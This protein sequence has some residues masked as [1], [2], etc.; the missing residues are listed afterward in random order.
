[1]EKFPNL[2]NKLKKWFITYHSS[3]PLDRELVTLLKSTPVALLNQV[4]NFVFGKVD[5]VIEVTTPEQ[6]VVVPNLAT[7]A[8]NDI[9]LKTYYASDTTV[10]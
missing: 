8:T 2:L 4:H 3:F 6:I 9:F 1:M 7:L 5:A 10:T